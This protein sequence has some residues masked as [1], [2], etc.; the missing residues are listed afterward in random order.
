MRGIRNSKNRS[1]AGAAKALA[2]VK[3][4]SLDGVLI[5]GCAASLLGYSAWNMTRTSTVSAV[6]HIM[7]ERSDMGMPGELDALRA[8]VLAKSVIDDLG[9]ADNPQFA[10]EAP[11][12]T[13]QTLRQLAGRFGVNGDAPSIET[14]WAKNVETAIEPRTHV[15][16]VV[17][18]LQNPQ[19]AVRVANALANRYVQ[20]APVAPRATDLDVLRQNVDFLQRQV[21]SLRE[22]APA[23]ANSKE[24]LQAKYDAIAALLKQGQVFDA[25]EQFDSDDMRA[26]TQERIRI[27]AQIQ[28]ESKTLLEQHPKMIELRDQLAKLEVQ[29]RAGV[30]KADA[31]LRKDLQNARAAAPSASSSTL[32]E[33]EPKLLAAQQKLNDELMKVANGE[34]APVKQPASHI[35]VPAEL[36]KTMTLADAASKNTN[37][38][39]YGAGLGLGLALMRRAFRRKPKPLYMPKAVPPQEHFAARLDEV[40]ASIAEAKQRMEPVQAAPAAHP[41]RDLETIL[42]RQTAPGL[43]LYASE[44][45]LRDCFPMLPALSGDYNICVMDLQSPPRARARLG[46]SDVLAGTIELDHAVFQDNRTG[47]HHIAAGTARRDSFGLELVIATLQDCYDLLIIRGIDVLS[48]D[49]DT[50]APLANIA[51]LTHAP[52]MAEATFV[53]QQALEAEYCPHIL[54]DGLMR[55]KMREAA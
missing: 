45:P 21:Q 19:L 3:S 7:V 55:E 47:F 33:L 44:Q 25:A 17:V 32:A 4:L 51:V 24:Q 52:E 43:M 11:A 18:T 10:V 20:S 12:S 31:A 39:L 28:I 6:A 27:K 46:L 42:R 38:A 34:A 2:V 36:P 23:P 37:Q 22:L 53:L 54:Y 50:I 35:V 40:V 48:D 14:R 8:P 49:F 41:G 26:L 9:L 29:I 30:L 13:L 15:L 1:I 5:A 16:N